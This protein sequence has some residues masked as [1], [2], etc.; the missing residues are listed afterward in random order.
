MK[1]TI[2]PIANGQNLLD[3]LSFSREGLI[4]GAVIAA[5]IVAFMLILRLVGERIVER[6]PD[7]VDWRG[8][9]GA[10]LA[11]TGIVFMVVTA[12]EIV[13]SY[14]PLP[15][16]IDRPIHIIFVIVAAIQVAVWLRELV[17]GALRHRVGEDPGESTL[18]NAMAIVRVL[19]SFTAFALAMIFILDNLGVN[20]TTLIAGLGIGGIAIGFAAQGIFSDLFAALSIVFDR[21]FRRGDTV[22]YG[23]T[24]GTVE[25]IGLKTTRIRAASGEQVIMS[26][27]QL[28][29]QEIHN[30]ATARARRTWLPFGVIY[31]TP[32]ELLERMPE[33]IDAA[34]RPIRS[35]R[36]IRCCI[37]GFGDSSIDFEL[38]YDD[39]STEFDS[40]AKHRSAIC[41]SIFKLFAENGVEFAYPTQTTFT[42]APDGTMIMPYASVQPATALEP[43]T[44]PKPSR[45]ART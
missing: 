3:W 37:T 5:V 30:L 11:R 43:R 17:M 13:T 31:Q 21:P 29:D 36:M 9:I 6:H 24:T 22:R 33:I 8:I 1:P 35:C 10:V 39:K 4:L 18:G 45:K 26:N 16:K 19:V 41:L 27:K 2:D 32:P 15:A 25:Q 28:L 38:V 23:T 20:V 7:C 14:A 42:S 12:I 40:L 44:P 34:V